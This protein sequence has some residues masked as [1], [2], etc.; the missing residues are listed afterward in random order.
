MTEENTQGF[1]LSKGA[2]KFL[3]SQKVKS[4]QNKPITTDFIFQIEKATKNKLGLYSCT[5]LDHDSKY[6]GFLLQYEQKDGAPGV[7]DI[8]NVKKKFW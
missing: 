6:G 3:E 1:N 2:I 4:G 5:L 7:G 8:I